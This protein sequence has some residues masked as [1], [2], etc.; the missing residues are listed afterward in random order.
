M[1]TQKDVLIAAKCA[2][3]FEMDFSSTHLKVNKMSI[4]NSII[5]TAVALS[6]YN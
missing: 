2:F 1:V 5:V 4:L 3:Q 6:G